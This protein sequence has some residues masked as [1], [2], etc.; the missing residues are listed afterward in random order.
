MI[1]VSP[2]HLKRYY[3]KSRLENVAE[4]VGECQTSEGLA[5]KKS[6]THSGR[7]SQPRTKAE[8]EGGDFS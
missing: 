2:D 5:P 8:V 3:G 6:Q 7:L 1:A 4:V